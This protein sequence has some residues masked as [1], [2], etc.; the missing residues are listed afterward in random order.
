M[1]SLSI[2]VVDDDEPTQRVL[3]LWLELHGH[4]VTCA[5]GGHAALGALRAGTFDLVITDVL[6]P[7]GDGLE[8][9]TNVRRHDPE[10]AV[11]AISG[12]GAHVAS[13]TCLQ[14][15]HSAGAQALLLKPFKQ[16]QLLNAMRYV[17]GIDLTAPEIARPS[18]GGRPTRKMR[19]FAGM[20]GEP[21]E[22]LRTR[23]SD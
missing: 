8:L 4:A 6:M 23:E 3:Q 10:L 16:D 15:A 7:D 12:G 2:L 11:L 14:R 22:P 19:L 9:I 21:A 17:L 20:A 18:D 13:S 5:N 1:K